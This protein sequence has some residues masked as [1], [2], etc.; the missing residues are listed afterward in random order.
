MITTNTLKLNFSQENEVR[1]LAVNFFEN[2]K[3]DDYF[4]FSLEGTRLNLK[5]IRHEIVFLVSSEDGS[6]FITIEI[7]ENKKPLRSTLKL[8]AR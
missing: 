1:E 7:D 8:I 5:T 3:C 2:K 4:E 6:F